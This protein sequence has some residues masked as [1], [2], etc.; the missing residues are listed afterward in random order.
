MSQAVSQPQPAAPH[1]PGR[2]AAQAA[3]HRL[4]GALE[5]ALAEDA[6]RLV[7]HPRLVLWSG[8]RAGAQ[9]V[10]RWPDRNRGAVPT[11]AVLPLAEECGAVAEIGAWTLARA[12]A[13]AA[14][15]AAGVVSVSVP[16]AL[17]RADLHRMV[18]QALD[19]AGLPPERLA[20]EFAEAALHADGAEAALA[21][22][23]L[24]DLGCRVVVDDFGSEMASL[25]LLRR[26]PLTGV[27]LD[28][29]LVRS[30]PE[31]QQD[32]AMI[33]AIVGAAHALGMTVIGSGVDSEAQRACLAALGCDEG[34]GYLFSGLEPLAGLGGD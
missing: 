25:R 18:H 17:L 1:G 6:F 11:G 22:S 29:A 8:R 19:R 30:L 20:L 5:R 15:W 4:R 34:Q 3:R 32:S 26:L 24:R 10:P 21:L 16:A 12:C 14:R 2:R 28:R 31:E 27:K 7:F 9:A 23:A 13:A 33:C